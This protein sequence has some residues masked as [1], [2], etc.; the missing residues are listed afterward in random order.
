VI[1]LKARKHQSD[2]IRFVYASDRTL[3]QMGGF[4]AVFC[5]A[6]R[7]HAGRYSFE[8]FE[9][10]ALFLETLVRPGGLLVIHNSPYRFGDTAGRGSYETIPVAAPR[11]IGSFLP[12][13][14]TEVESDGSIFRKL[15]S[16]RATM[17]G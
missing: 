2:R 1:L 5:M 13:G 15:K 16:D 10:R 12:D 3:S 11:D 9:E 8:D 6:V 7:R 14:V 17:A 4:D